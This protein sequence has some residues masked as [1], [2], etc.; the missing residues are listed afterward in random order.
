MAPYFKAGVTDPKDWAAQLRSP[1]PWGE[2]TSGK[3]AIPSPTAALA[4][5]VNVSYVLANWDQVSNRAR[6]AVRGAGTAG[7]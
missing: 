1:A 2:I 7:S 6:R 4:G 3:L 5:V